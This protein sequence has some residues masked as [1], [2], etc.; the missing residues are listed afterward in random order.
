MWRPAQR[1]DRKPLASAM[2]RLSLAPMPPTSWGVVEAYLRN[3]EI[4]RSLKSRRTI[5]LTLI[6]FHSMT[7]YKHYRRQHV[8][9]LIPEGNDHGEHGEGHQRYK[10]KPK[11]AEREESTRLYEERGGVRKIWING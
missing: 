10:D 4:I 6:S 3:N 7:K 5:A 2:A 9:I 11:V 1:V 8:C